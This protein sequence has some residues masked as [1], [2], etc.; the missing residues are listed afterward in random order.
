[1]ATLIEFYPV[2]AVA[3]LRCDWWQVS[4]LSVSL[5]LHDLWARVD[6][7][8]GICNYN[9]IVAYFLMLLH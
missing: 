3:I 2:V 8:V 7:F 4:I 5:H 1:M 6:D 9:Y